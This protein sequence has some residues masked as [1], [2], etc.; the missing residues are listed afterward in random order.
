MIPVAR[1]A[2]ALLGDHPRR[3]LPHL[4]G[5]LP[6]PGPGRA[7]LALPFILQ[8]AF[9]FF[10]V[11]FQFVGMFWFM[12]KGGVDVY[13]PGDVK[14]R[15]TDVWGQDAVLDRVKENIIFLKDP[16]AIETR[17]GYV[18]GGIL[19]WGPRGRARPSSPRQSPA[20]P[21]TLSSSSTPVRSSTCSWVSAS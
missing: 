20:R 16:E 17:G 7:L 2:S 18:P 21:R 5:G 13:Y 10:F 11:I 12:S 19:L 6:L 9:A 15:F 4:A 1:A 8:L 3:V 14:T